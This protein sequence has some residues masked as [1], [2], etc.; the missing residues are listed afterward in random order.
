MNQYQVTLGTTYYNQRYFNVGKSASNHL[1]N[2]NE[3]LKIIL[4]DGQIIHTTINRTINSNGSVRFY[5]RAEWNQFIQANY[6]L[7]QV[8]TF[9]V[10]NAN[11]ITIIPNA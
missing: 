6:N 8:I 7:H 2:H 11:T 3:S 9:Q 1:G 5:G 4:L 10:T